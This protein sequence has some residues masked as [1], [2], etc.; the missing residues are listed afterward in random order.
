MPNPINNDY[1]AIMKNLQL[2]FKNA[3][4]KDV[5]HQTDQLRVYCLVD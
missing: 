3:V 4:Y 5:L 1:E 2:Y